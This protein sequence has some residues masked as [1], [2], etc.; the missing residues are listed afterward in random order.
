MTPSEQRASTGL[1][2]KDGKEIYRPRYAVSLSRQDD[3]YFFVRC[4]CPG[5]T[6]QASSRN[7][8]RTTECCRA[9]L[10]SQYDP[11]ARMAWGVGANS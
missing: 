6:R 11:R 9:G 7:S 5:F 10:Q 2:E 1:V 4:V 8:W 3:L